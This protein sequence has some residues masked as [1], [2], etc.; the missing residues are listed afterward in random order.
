MSDKQR[1]LFISV[2]LRVKAFLGT[3]ISLEDVVRVN[4]IDW[5]V[6]VRWSQRIGSVE[7]KKWLCHTPQQDLRCKCCAVYCYL[8]RLCQVCRHVKLITMYGGEKNEQKHPH[9]DMNT[10]LGFHFLT[11]N[12]FFCFLFFP[13]TDKPT[14]RKIKNDTMRERE[15]EKKSKSAFFEAGKQSHG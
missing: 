12:W 7:N 9:L 6:A 5:T 8:L 1:R 14:V 2:W 3:F 15:R 13:G 11:T 10:V 4:E